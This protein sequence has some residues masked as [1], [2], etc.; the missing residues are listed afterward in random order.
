MKASEPKRT[1]RDRGEME[2]IMFKLFEQQPNWTL[3]ELIHKT[4]QPALL[5]VLAF[6]LMCPC[7]TFRRWN[8]TIK[9]HFMLLSI[10]CSG[11]TW[12]TLM[13]QFSCFF[14]RAFVV[15]VWLCLHQR[16]LLR[17]PENSIPEK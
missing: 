9:L 4:D 13:F 3:K 11:E 14:F 17:C 5:F 2:E 15:F 12:L 6:Y 1:R 8:V 16:H 10:C 7:M